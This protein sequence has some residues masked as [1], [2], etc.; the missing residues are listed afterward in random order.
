MARL[1]GHQ[2]GPRAV[3]TR[4]RDWLQLRRRKATP[5]LLVSG[6]PA[7]ESA[8]VADVS[9]N[10]RSPRVAGEKMFDQRHEGLLR[11]C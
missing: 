5:R 4:H 11:R 6:R 3:T 1:A 2:H 10:E 9:S 7:L 8:I